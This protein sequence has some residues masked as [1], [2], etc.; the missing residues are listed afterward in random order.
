MTNPLYGRGCALA[1]VQAVLLADAF[2]SHPRDPVARAATYEAGN[3]VEVEPWF[4]S[5]VQ[6]DK[7]GADPAGSG[8]L[9]G[10]GGGGEGS[11]AA[12]AMGAVFVAAQT[13]PVIGRGIARFMNLL[14]TPVQLMA[15]GELMTRIAEVMA[16]PSAYPI[17]PR[18]GPTRSELLEQ[19]G[20]ELVA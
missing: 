8:S 11:D 15:D 2:A 12:T 18:V 5:S 16:D 1:A 7:L 9:G 17:P 3:V 19:L 6:M 10:G 13:D 4:E 14:A 20:G